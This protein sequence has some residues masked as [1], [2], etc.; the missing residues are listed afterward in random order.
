LTEA[1]GW[2]PRVALQDGIEITTRWFTD[3]LN[4]GR[5]RWDSYTL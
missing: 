1:T 5:Y 2:E 4:L 3:P